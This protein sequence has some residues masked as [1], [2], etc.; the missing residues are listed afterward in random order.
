[1]GNILGRARGGNGK[2]YL[3]FV[4]RGLRTVPCAFEVRV[5]VR[6]TG[7]SFMMFSSLLECESFLLSGNTSTPTA[8]VTP[9]V[10]VRSSRFR[11]SIPRLR[12]Y[13]CKSTSQRY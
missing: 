13:F 11:L 9:G 8:S 7:T 1:M 6:E 2:P 4:V 5:R 3:T 12:I 10:E